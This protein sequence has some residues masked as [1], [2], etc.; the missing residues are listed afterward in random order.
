[1][2]GDVEPTARKK[3]GYWA[4]PIPFVCLFIFY[5]T[6]NCFLSP[7]IYD[8]L[9]WVLPTLLLVFGLPWSVKAMRKLREL[10]YVVPLK[11]HSPNP[12]VGRC[13][14]YSAFAGLLGGSFGL[15]VVFCC[16]MSMVYV[17]ANDV[18]TFHSRV[19]IRKGRRE[20]GHI[21]LVRS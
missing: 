16:F 11:G 7:R 21:G 18:Q 4:L 13:V 8:S 17:S 15:V 20:A 9:F 2:D 3:C 14:A 5:S 12:S 19:G 10:G 6:R 1:M